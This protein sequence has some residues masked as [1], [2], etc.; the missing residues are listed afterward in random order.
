MFYFVVVMLC[1]VAW[2]FEVGPLL[3]FCVCYAWVYL[4]LVFK[5]L[6]VFLTYFMECIS[7]E[8]VMLQLRFLMYLVVVVCDLLLVHA[9]ACPLVRFESHRA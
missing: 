1:V 6:D 4:C 2:C 5:I 9:G 3:S 7:K 8:H